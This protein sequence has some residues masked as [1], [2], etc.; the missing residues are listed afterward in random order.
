MKVAILGAGAFGTALGGILANNGY[1]VDYYDPRIEKERLGDVLGGAGFIVLSVPSH[2]VSYLLPRLPKNIPLLIA[3]KGIL[4]D[5]GFKNFRDWMVLSG[6]GFA[7]DI[8]AKKSTVFSIT[9]DRITKMFAANYIKF[10][11]VDDR[12]GVLMCGALKNVYAILAGYKGLKPQT[13]T[14]RNFLEEVSSEM[15]EIL[16]INSCDPSTVY[17]ACGIGDLTLTCSPQSR[18][19]E[20]GE[21]VRLNPNYRPEKTVEGWT[22]LTKIK[23]SVIKI[24]QG[25][26]KLNELIE[27]SKEWY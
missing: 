4:S 19:Y 1:D 21:K 22:A 2:A 11:P 24:P 15:A 10:D 27:L 14:M 8:K 23:R 3:T 16:K 9:D 18:N 25:M 5:E 12:H 17:H 26:K 6:P 13:I 20:F 7:D